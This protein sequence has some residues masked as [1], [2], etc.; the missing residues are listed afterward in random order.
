MDD[1]GQPVRFQDSFESAIEV[2]EADAFGILHDAS[3]TSE[4]LSDEVLWSLYTPNEVDN[5]A[6]QTHPSSF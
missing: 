1:I 3:P 2:F 5:V 6:C 4:H